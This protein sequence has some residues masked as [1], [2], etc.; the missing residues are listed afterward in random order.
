MKPDYVASFL[1]DKPITTFLLVGEKE[2]RATR[3]GKAFLRLEL[4]DCTGSIEARIWDNV[5]YV[6]SA[7][8]RDDIVKIQ[9]RVESYRNKLQ[10]A[11]DKIRRATPAEIDLADYFAHT[12]ED[13][14]SLYTR[15]CAHATAV[16]NPWLNRLLVSVIEDPAIV[17]RLKRAPAAKMMHHAFLGGLLEHMIS[18]CDLCR[19]VAG[20]YREL[21]ADLL[22]SGAI[23][24][25]I[26]KLDELCYERAINY[27]VEGQ[28]L[29]HIILELEQVTK[30]MDAIEGFPADL[31]T[32]IKHLLISHHGKYEFGS[33]K[34]PMF[35]EALVLHYLDDLDS[36]MAAARAVLGVP[37][38]DG[39]WTGYS[40]ALN[41]R[42]LRL[43]LFRTASGTPAASPCL[44]TAEVPNAVTQLEA[45]SSVAI[46]DGVSL[47][48]LETVASLTLDTNDGAAQ[49]AG[50]GN[51]AHAAPPGSS[52]DD[53]N[54][55]GKEA[56]QE[57]APGVS[58]GPK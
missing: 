35:R 30:K 50:S 12:T 37:G 31:K 38:G 39:E 15:L 48:S 24:H 29:G 41:R 3:E 28:L 8:D 26:G 22:V 33:P 58:E 10:L 51:G 53:R 19:A 16:T 34:L 56:R 45:I 2:L 11:V 18:L 52:P 1:P 42:L 46:P 54:A 6:L 14:E 9:G 43:D 49:L 36:K 7:F 13:V 27:T 57:G 4:T 25:D 47:E 20:H 5:E 17:P 23:L 21:D 32:L 40:S 55:A 44:P